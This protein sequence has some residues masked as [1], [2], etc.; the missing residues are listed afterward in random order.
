MSTRREF[1]KLLCAAPAAGIIVPE[2]LGVAPATKAECARVS[3]AGLDDVLVLR[4]ALQS[5]SLN[6][7]PGISDVEIQTGVPYVRKPNVTADVML[8]L[9]Q[10]DMV[11]IDKF[12]SIFNHRVGLV[13]L[14]PATQ[15]ATIG[16]TEYRVR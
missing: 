15:Y 1:V 6:M 5:V 14:G 2:V 3:L 10:I 16:G 12:G 8:A 7:D 9:S 4:G 13:D 11:H